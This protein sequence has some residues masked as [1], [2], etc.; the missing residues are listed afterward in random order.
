MKRLMNLRVFLILGVAMLVASTFVTYVFITNS[1]RL[2]IFSI[3]VALFAVLLIISIIYKF[4]F[5]YLFSAVLIFMSIPFINVYFRSKNLDK[6][7]KFNESEVTVYGKFSENFSYTTSG[8]LKLTLDD[9]Y[10]ISNGETHKIDGKIQLYTN[11]SHFNLDDFKLGRY[12]S[13]STELSF[14]FLDGNS[15]SM[16]YLNRNIVAS[17]YALF[18]EITFTNDY[19]ITLRDRIR[20]LTL[21]LERCHVSIDA[22]VAT[23]YASALAVLSED[24]KETGA[25]LIDIGGGNA[26]MAIFSGGFIRYA[27]ALPL[28]G[29]LL[30][31]DIAQ[32]LKTPLPDAERV[33]TLYGSAFLSPQDEKETLSV[34]LIGETEEGTLTT[35][36]RSYLISIMVPRIEEML[37]LTNGYLKSQETDDYAT[38]RIVLCGGCSLIPGLREKASAMLEAQVRLGKPL[39]IKGLPDFMPSTTFS[40]ATGLLRYAANRRIHSEDKRIKP[41]TSSTNFIKR[42]TKWLMQNF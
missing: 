11:P 10:I 28:G 42:V 7:Y 17:G 24:E 32:V 41:T 20:N 19:N 34:P 6:N 27:A 21:A 9:V 33:K 36:P 12:I 4:K 5:L 22:K 40:T 26:S 25:T 2:I 16:F 23:P 13:A 8:N 37:E 15:S 35:L 18:Y 14:Y 30:T 31:K 29:L 1:L 3:L 38:R 39:M